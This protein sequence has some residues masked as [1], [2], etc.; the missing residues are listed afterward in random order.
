MRL[1]VIE[2]SC[3]AYFYFDFRDQARQSIRGLISSLLAQL[4]AQSHPYR[5]I[6]SRLHTKYVGTSWW[7]EDYTLRKCLK[8]MLALPRQPPVYI[9]LDALD[10]CPVSGMPSPRDNVLGLIK[11]LVDMHLHHL[12]ICATSQQEVYIGANLKPPVFRHIWFDTRREHAH[13]IA[14]YI[15]S[16]CESDLM[17]KTWGDDVRELVIDTLIEKNHG[18]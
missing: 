17:M 13:D 4:V 9:I 15:R 10:E 12:H 5:D 1:R 18:V 2:S 3:V 14:T 8:E 6:F 11:E 16:T 7:C